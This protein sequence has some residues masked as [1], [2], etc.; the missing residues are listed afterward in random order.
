MNKDRFPSR[1]IGRIDSKIKFKIL[2]NPLWLLFLIFLRFLCILILSGTEQSYSPNLVHLLCSRDVFFCS[3]G[4]SFG[5]ESISRSLAGWLPS[6]LAGHPQ[7]WQCCTSS[8]SLDRDFHGAVP[9][10]SSIS[11][12][13]SS[14][15]TQQW[16]SLPDSKE[17]GSCR[18]SLLSGLSPHLSPPRP[19]L[20]PSSAC[21][22]LAL[23]FLKI[24]WTIC[25]PSPST[26]EW[27]RK[28][29][30]YRCFLISFP[31]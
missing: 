20:L 27:H 29:F 21:R 3:R 17:T 8:M 15:P 22:R 18:P 12:P 1:L 9:P 28:T 30:F 24:I 13:G 6:W 25:D 2:P 16:S 11:L 14:G 10:L 7:L 26:L 4:S 31:C 5:T 19:P 23:I